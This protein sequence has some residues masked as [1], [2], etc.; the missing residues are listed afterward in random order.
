MSEIIVRP[1]ETRDFESVKRLFAAQNIDYKLPDFDAKTFLVRAVIEEGGEVTT[2]AFLRKVANAYYLADPSRGTKRDKLGRLFIMKRELTA[3][4]R[5][6]DFDE[7]EAFLPPSM[8]QFGRLLVK[9]LGWHRN[10]WPC[11]SIDLPKEAS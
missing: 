10:L 3:A 11:F 5:R 2:A 6:V 7:V 9:H 1:Y 4:A 8:E